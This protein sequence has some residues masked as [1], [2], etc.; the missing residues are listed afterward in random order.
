[1]ECWTC[2]SNTGENRISPGPTIFE[3]K[4]WLVEHAYPIKIL[5]WLVIVLKRHAEALH[6]LTVEEFIELAQIQARLIPLL[7][8][9]LHCEKEY[10]SCYAEME[11]FRHIH[12]HVFA[13]PAGIADELKGGRSFAL[14]KVTPEE[15]VS[16]VE[17]ISFC[18]LLRAK[19]AY[20]L[21]H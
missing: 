8:E 19:L 17:I 4:Y 7:H 10:M 16:A 11:H 9:E 3:G 6:E 12:I 21:Q 14:L 2:K 13:R 15:A 1:M 18:K 5:G 20:T